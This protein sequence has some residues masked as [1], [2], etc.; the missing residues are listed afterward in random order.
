[1]SVPSI[2]GAQGADI[3]DWHNGIE[4]VTGLNT[5]T[6]F[7]HY[8]YTYYNANHRDWYKAQI[9]GGVNTDM[10][11]EGFSYN[12]AIFRVRS[13]VPT[14]IADSAFSRA[15]IRT[16]YIESKVDSTSRQNDEGGLLRYIGNYAFS[17]TG[18][19][20]A[21]LSKVWNIGY[22]AFSHANLVGDYGSNDYILSLD[23]ARMIGDEAFFYNTKLRNVYMPRVK[24]IGVNAFKN[25]NDLTNIVIN[26]VERIGRYAFNSTNLSSISLPNTLKT[27]EHGAFQDA[28]GEN[29]VSVTIPSSV[30]HLGEYSFSY[31]NKLNYMSV[32]SPQIT[33]V[34]NGFLAMCRGLTN[35]SFVGDITTIG[36][37][38]FS[39]TGITEAPFP[40]VKYIGESAFKGSR[41]NTA[42][43]PKLQ[44]IG[45]GAFSSISTLTEF[46][47]VRNSGDNTYLNIEQDAFKDSAALRRVN[48]TAPVTIHSNVFRGATALTSVNIPKV[49]K[50]GEGAFVDSSKLTN[51]S[52][53]GS[54]IIND[55]NP[56]N[57]V[58]NDATTVN[59]NRLR[60]EATKDRFWRNW[61]NPSK[62]NYINSP[63]DFTK[64][65]SNNITIKGVEYGKSISSSLSI[66]STFYV[67]AD[68]VV[69]SSSTYN[70]KKISADAFN[71][72][73]P[74]NG[75]INTTGIT[76]LTIPNSI[77][78]I[79]ERAFANNTTLR[80]VILPNNSSLTQIKDGTFKNTGLTS[81]TMPSYI[82]RIGAE[83]F[84]D[85][86]SLTRIEAN[87]V[88]EIGREAFKN[89]NIQNIA[90]PKATTIGERAFANNNTLE[91]VDLPEATTIKA[92]AFSD[93]PN[94][95]RV[96]IPKVTVIEEGAFVNCPNLTEIV[97]N[98]NITINTSNKVF[99]DNTLVTI[100]RLRDDATKD[101][102]WKNWGNKTKINYINSPYDF[103]KDS[104][105][106]ITI[107]GVEDGKALPSSNLSIPSEFNVKQDNITSLKTYN[108]TKI[109]A[110]AFN[111]TSPGNSVNN[112]VNLTSV[113]IPDTIIDIGENAFANNTTLI[114]ATI[115]N[116]S[117]LTQIKDGIFQNTG[118]TSITIPDY[119]TRIGQNA[120][121]D[122]PNLTSRIEA[123]NVTEIG[124]EAFKNSAIQRITLPKVTII[125][126]RA[127]EN[128]AR[129]ENVSL[130]EVTT[131]KNGAFAS[132]SNLRTVEIPKVANIEENAFIGCSKLPEI[133]LNGNVNINTANRVFS[134]NTIVTINRLRDDVTKDTNWKNWGNKSKINYIN[135]PYDF[136]KDSSNNITIKG[137]EDGKALP[138][139]NLSIPSEFNVKQDNI[140][141]LKTYNITKIEAN[142]F[143]KTSP[144]NSVNNTVN[145]ISVDIPSSITDIGAGAFSNNTT[146]REFSFNNSNL[147]EIKES[148]FENTGLTSIQLPDTVTKLGNKAFKNTTNLQV[149]IA[150]SNV[151]QVGEE[152]FANSAIEGITLPKAK[153]INERAFEN[154]DNLRNI[155]LPEV[156]DIKVR[157]FFNNSNL[158]T[159]LVP[160]VTNIE[161]AAFVNC[162]KLTSIILNGSVNIN[163]TNRVFSDNTLIIINRLRD[164]ANKDRNW[165]LWGNAS[166][167]NYVNSPYDF[168]KDQNNNITITGV[169]F[170]KTLNPILNIPASFNVSADKLITT[171]ITY[172]ITKIGANA[173]NKTSP[174]NNINN[175][176]NLTSVSIPNSIIEIGT[177]AFTD[178]TTLREFSFGNSRLTEIKPSTFE[179]TDITSIKLPNGITKIGAKAF[180]GTASLESRIEANNVVEIGEE[181]FKNSAIQSIILPKATIIKT[182]AFSGNSNLETIEI[183]KI[184]TIEANT[185]INSPMLNNIK[186]NGTVQINSTAN[187]PNNYKTFSNNTIVTINRL[188]DDANKD[189]NWEKWGNPANIKY[190][191]SPFN[192]EKDN[193]TG[194]ITLTGFETGK[195]NALEKNFAIAEEFIVTADAANGIKKEE[196]PV[197]GIAANAFK[198]SNVSANTLTIP[199][200][201]TKIG[202]NAFENIG[203]NLREIV[204]PNTI[205]SLGA[206]VFSNNP[207]LTRVNIPSNNTLNKIENDT[208]KNTGLLTISLPNT[209]T[210]IGESA[211]ENTKIQGSV[212]LPNVNT[213]N[214]KAFANN[215]NITSVVAPNLETIEDKAFANE[216][217][218]DTR[219]ASVVMPKINSIGKDAFINNAN[220]KTTSLITTRKKRS[221]A[222]EITPNIMPDTLRTI[223]A[224]AFVGTGF[225]A[226]EL[227]GQIQIIDSVNGNG[228]VFPD[229]TDVYINRVIDSNG[230]D[231]NNEN[232]GASSINYL[233]KPKFKVVYESNKDGTYKST[234]TMISSKKLTI[235]SI[236]K[237][238]N[239]QSIT[240]EESEDVELKSNNELKQRTII[241]DNIPSDKITNFS[242]TVK[243][244]NR[245]I[246]KSDWSINK[247][248]HYLFEDDTFAVQLLAGKYYPHGFETLMPAPD[249]IPSGKQ[250]V[251]WSET[252]DAKTPIYSYATPLSVNGNIT[253]YALFSEKLPEQEF[254]ITEIS[255]TTE[256]NLTTEKESSTAST[257][258]SSEQV[259][260]ITTKKENII[261]TTTNFVNPEDLENVETTTNTIPTVQEDNTIVTSKNDNILDDNTQDLIIDKDG[262]VIDEDGNIII[263]KQ[264]NILDNSLTID[265]YEN[266]Y[267]K[268]GNLI[269]DKNGYLYDKN[270]NIIG[271]ININRKILNTIYEND[272]IKIDELDIDFK[273]KEYNSNLENSLSR[274]VKKSSENFLNS[275]NERGI[276]ISKKENLKKPNFGFEEMRKVSLLLILLIILII[277]FIVYVIKKKSSN[278]ENDL[279]I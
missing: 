272:S 203:N 179:N 144:G 258:V 79:G 212:L 127:F 117:S 68:S 77:I 253:L 232:W 202:A 227:N 168:T 213:L 99:S 231:K 266:I 128:N 172:N 233:N 255:S 82:T 83:A 181:A 56:S 152:A 246:E 277:I 276:E 184:K 27:I 274:I 177:G 119:I 228:E 250:F 174:G 189:A 218:Q 5:N 171:P 207:N 209:I 59:I 138:S 90:L 105:N 52:L 92:G 34:P 12:P 126:E 66:P 95:Q 193:N 147:T 188:R 42:S 270:K 46:N 187:E 257:E 140:T 57:K 19:E 87:N 252:K 96:V 70:I 267:D 243:S 64:D 134:D 185:F 124:Q 131:I 89:S 139:S 238:I 153:I 11:I 245:D 8:Y 198:G 40:V 62:I 88:I 98:G 273:Q 229:T 65:S 69:T 23:E 210:E 223:K 91:T 219:L 78:D 264:G 50:I 204:M 125:N 162:N 43:F 35:V 7:S 114:S 107:K 108:I 148:T 13:I 164:Y 242:F 197:T 103:T 115:P 196:L 44:E 25:N 208:F 84:K 94:L 236:E 217:K 241:L 38:A 48:I 194:E 32:R 216:L 137:V 110:N 3:N 136:T 156:S 237:D 226:I 160:K 60:D 130:P 249:S 112:T 109:E 53:N 63:Y 26:E 271:K 195:A 29:T 221:A 85:T 161:T 120:F 2:K 4:Y 247:Q 122:T 224:G 18:L 1:M 9:V 118:L 143:N 15:S 200:S 20:R 81:V 36:R 10:R 71:K 239:H 265:K 167:I 132:N 47:V 259:S 234:I 145:L 80:T 205:T 159:A 14:G 192:Y 67:P 22:A 215:V 39:E 190:A 155:N 278:D 129:L 157:A 230:L 141:S 121:K 173:F 51:I 61:G 176:V 100:N 24:Q 55:S 123:N 244:F 275:L 102:Y 182:G 260:E 158:L 269:V 72:I 222:N 30:T 142:A 54:V 150:A 31:N 186:L 6:T 240:V 37:Y 169:E 49:N 113:R 279:T 101:R 146:L 106:N 199:N 41:L 74:A 86:N 28:F 93:N 183:P 17:Q 76:S 254:E 97:L 75:I 256:T 151:I 33:A 165:K 73:N 45:N 178:N 268:Y 170:G 211:F 251:G 263:D 135:S 163:S 58:F 166:K 104:S 149:P 262:N 21:S 111:K 225:D 154:N 191:N 220:L 261:E 206:G 201:I 175:D 133:R 180:K 248:V 235:D 16:L 214:D 116:N